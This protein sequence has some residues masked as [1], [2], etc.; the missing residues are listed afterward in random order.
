MRFY[1]KGGSF[2]KKLG[3]YSYKQR[4]RSW[5]KNP[6]AVNLATWENLKKHGY[7]GLLR[8]KDLEWNSDKPFGWFTRSGWF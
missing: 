8:A 3:V 4:R 7:K 6:H 2:I 5:F 1:T